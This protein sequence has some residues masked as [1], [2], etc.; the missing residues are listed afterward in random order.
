VGDKDI[1]NQ[2]LELQ[3]AHH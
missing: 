3:P 1:K 2:L